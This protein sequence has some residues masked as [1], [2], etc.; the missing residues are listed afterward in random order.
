MK[1]KNDE[2]I[3]NLLQSKFNWWNRFWEQLIKIVKVKNKDSSYQ[4]CLDSI[5]KD[6]VKKN[7]EEGRKDVAY[8][9]YLD[10]VKDHL[11]TNNKRLLTKQEEEI[12]VAHL[13]AVALT[14]CNDPKS[15][16]G[17]GITQVLGIE[18]AKKVSELHPDFPTPT[19]EQVDQRVEEVLAIQ[20]YLKTV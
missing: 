11:K 3:N 20:N 18:T 8:Q 9:V 6:V 19:K 14:F 5:R 4:E 13:T 15:G 10:K 12:V 1:E 7:S 2:L 16:K 17:L